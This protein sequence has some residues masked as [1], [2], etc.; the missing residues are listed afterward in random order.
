MLVYT[1]YSSRTYSDE[2]SYCIID[3]VNMKIPYLHN[4]QGYGE[5]ASSITLLRDNPTYID[6]NA[7][8][9]WVFFFGLFTYAAVMFIGVANAY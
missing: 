4:T 2:G 7:E 8:F 6:G 5:T 1:L 9:N 3:P